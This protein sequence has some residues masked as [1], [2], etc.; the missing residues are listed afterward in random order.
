MTNRFL[1]TILYVFL[2]KL[3][4]IIEYISYFELVTVL[5]YTI[6]VGYML[7]HSWAN[8]SI[9]GFLVDEIHWRTNVSRLFCFLRK[10]VNSC[11]VF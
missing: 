6:E 2:V 4:F 7:G 8:L 3:Y 9:V 1:L 10:K 11:D 5:I